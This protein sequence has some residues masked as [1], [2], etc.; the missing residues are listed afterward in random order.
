MLYRHVLVCTGVTYPPLLSMT[1]NIIN[2]AMGD[3]QST[4]GRG[5]WEPS[6]CTQ[7]VVC[8]FDK[9]PPVH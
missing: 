9:P 2:R 7:L 5:T 3:L 1:F 8:V 6:K 4:L